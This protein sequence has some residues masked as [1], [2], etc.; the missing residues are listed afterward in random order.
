MARYAEAAD[1][2]R[3]RDG[4]LFAWRERNA[5]GA[6]PSL[7]ASRRHGEPAEVRVNT[8]TNRVIDPKSR[9]DPRRMVGDRVECCAADVRGNVV[10]DRFRGGGRRRHWDV[11]ACSGV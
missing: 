5:S 9:N 6:G 7:I 1:P 2:W 11:E 10:V 4:L 3:R 8:L